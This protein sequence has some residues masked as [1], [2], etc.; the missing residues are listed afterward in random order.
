MRRGFLAAPRRRRGVEAI[1]FAMILPL[2]FAML[3]ATVEFS[4]Y[5]FQRGGVADAARVA[6]RTA[7]QLDPRFDDVVADAAA[8]VLAE[9]HEVLVDCDGGELTCEVDIQELSDQFPP[10]VICDVTVSFKPLTGF[11]GTTGGGRGSISNI[12]RGARSWSG[13]GLL[14]EN[15]H[16]RSVAIYEGE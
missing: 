7:A 8:V 1:E 9:L 13:V 2:F 3:F 6:C 16:A 15:I 11:L 4:W 5:M 10:R 14:P 12:N